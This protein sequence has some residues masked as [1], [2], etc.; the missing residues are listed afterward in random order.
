M[1]TTGTNGIKVNAYNGELSLPN[2]LTIKTSQNSGFLGMPSYFIVDQRSAAVD[3]F[4]LGLGGT[5]AMDSVTVMGGG[6]GINVAAD[7][8]TFFGA[9]AGSGITTGK[10]NQFIGAFT[11]PLNDTNA[12]VYGLGENGE[13]LGAFLSVDGGDCSDNTVVGD[14]S[15][16]NAESPSSRNVGIGVQVFQASKN[17]ND[18]TFVGYQAGA[19]ASYNYDTNTLEKNVA[20][21]YR[22]LF[23]VNGENNVAIGSEA[24][25][26]IREASNNIILGP[27]TSAVLGTTPQ[28]VTVIGKNSR[29][30][31]IA[32]DNGVTVGDESPV[33]VHEFII[34]N[35]AALDFADDAAAAAGGVPVNGIYHTG[36]IIK[37]RLS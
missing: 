6:A 18:N 8:N 25:N 14:S 36:G 4:S 21:G 7:N 37:I 2:G 32:D 33:T 9:W 11:G 16:T 10:Y 13:I 28:G 17:L 29:V 15:F 23:R 19:L 1:S 5:Q 24:G 27:V 31:F 30:D 12:P 20:I 3:Y 34:S 35:G 26:G 22:S